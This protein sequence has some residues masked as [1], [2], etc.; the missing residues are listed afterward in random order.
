LASVSILGYGKISRESII[1]AILSQ[2]YSV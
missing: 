1:I 2:L